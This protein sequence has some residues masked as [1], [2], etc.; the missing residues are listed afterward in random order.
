MPGKSTR[1]KLSPFRLIGLATKSTVVP[2]KLDTMVLYPATLLKSAL[3]P[4]FG[5]PTRAILM[6]FPSNFHFDLFSHAVTDPHLSPVNLDQDR[7]SQK[8]AAENLQPVLRVDSQPAETL[9][10]PVAAMNLLHHSRHTVFEFFQRR[11][12]LEVLLA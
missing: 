11:D 2:G 8:A 3:L 7:S 1:V 6:N 9:T 4:Q 12:H 10:D 5:C